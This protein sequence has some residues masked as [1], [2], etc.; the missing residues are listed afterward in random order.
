MS[1]SRQPAVARRQS[2]VEAALGVFAGRSFEGVHMDEVAQRAGVSKALLYKHFPGKR[3]LYLEVIRTI[4]GQLRGAMADA[5]VDVPLEG[6]LGAAIHAYTTFADW[7]REHF[8]SLHHCDSGGDP[9]LE[10]EIE[11]VR[12]V[13]EERVL[14]VL[15]RT[16]Q[17]E[18]GLR[19][20][21]GFVEGATA[22][23]L[24]LPEGVMSQKQAAALMEW[25]LRTGLNQM[26]PYFEAAARSVST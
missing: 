12:T 11:S 21:M 20:V 10:A 17:M 3:G 14:G 6:Q 16:P 25:V 26:R 24:E 23:W 22:K 2:I 7:K 5:M 18:V 19:G 15:P 1:A 8:L 13:I 4:V 9:E